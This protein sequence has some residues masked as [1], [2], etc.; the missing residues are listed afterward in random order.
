MLLKKPLDR[1]R[2]NT[3]LKKAL[4][5]IKMLQRWMLAGLV[6]EVGGGGCEGE[7]LAPTLGVFL[8]LTESQGEIPESQRYL[9]AS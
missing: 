1:H 6:I 7:R 4:L 9:C 8:F 2:V 3:L 5:L